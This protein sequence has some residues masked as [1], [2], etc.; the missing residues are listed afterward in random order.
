M[1]ILRLFTVNGSNANNQGSK[2]SPSMVFILYD[3]KTHFFVLL[4]GWLISN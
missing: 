4:S 3:D 1:Q 2:C